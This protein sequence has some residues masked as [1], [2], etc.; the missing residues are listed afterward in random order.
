M[1]DEMTSAEGAPLLTATDLKISYGDF[2]A[3]KGATLT[4]NPGE[5]V[6]LV[7]ESGSGKTTLA[8]AVAGMLTD[9]AVRVEAAELSFAG[10]PVTQPATALP[11]ITEGVSVVFQDAMT[12]LDPTWRI[13][14]Q[15]TA[16]LRHRRGL[17]RTEA[18]F[19]A[20]QWLRRVGFSD[21]ERVMRLRPYELSGGM[22]QRAM[23]AVALC[24]EPRLIVADEPTSALD[25]TLA[26]LT[27]DLLKELTDESGA[28]L[29]IVTHDLQLCLEYADKLCVMKD[30]DVVEYATAASIQARP[31]HPYTRGLL[32]CVPTLESADLELLPTLESVMTEAERL[33][34]AAEA[35]PRD[36]K[37]AAS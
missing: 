9:P 22:R 7:G 26:R 29:V 20:V 23:I 12:S 5:R 34:A 3:V 25:A 28:A 32:A 11:T 24:G 21:P 30:G 14:G 8:M 36:L 16:V 33:Q 2:V 37:L 15:L 35:A 4:V 18:K 13:G 1:L 6:A 10:N 31:R 17:A 19:E 27:M